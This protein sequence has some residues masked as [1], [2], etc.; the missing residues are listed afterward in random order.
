[1]S[2]D[3]AMAEVRRYLDAKRTLPHDLAAIP[4]MDSR[5]RQIFLLESSIA[6]LA[7]VT[8]KFGVIEPHSK[9]GALGLFLKRVV[10]KAIG[11]YSRPVHEFDRTVIEA[12]QHVRQDM[13]GLQQQIDALA[14]E[15]SAPPPQ[16]DAF[17]STV[18]LLFANIV[19]V[20]SLRGAL[21]EKLPEIQ[22]TIEEMQATTERELADLKAALLE[23]WFPGVAPHK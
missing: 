18:E 14:A 4:Q 5:R 23:Q 19:T 1:M 20:Q 9:A 6:Q 7:E 8:A 11:W 21:Q 10:R 15:R 3:E 17:R 2:L 13:Q 16:M 12:L 22:S